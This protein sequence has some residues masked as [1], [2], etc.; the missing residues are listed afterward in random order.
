MPALTANQSVHG[1]QNLT[2]LLLL[3][4]MPSFAVA[5]RRRLSPWQFM[6]LVSLAIFFACKLATW[7]RIDSHLRTR[8]GFIRN[9]GYLFL[10]PGMNAKPFL[11]KDHSVSVPALR[12][13]LAAMIKTVAGFALVS[14]GTRRALSETSPSLFTA[15]AGML[16]LILIL[17]FGAFHLISLA[18]RRFG[19][20]AE[21]IMRAPLQATSLSEFWGRRWNLGFRQLTHEFVFTPV[22]KHLGAPGAIAASFLFSGLIHDLVISVPARGGYCL[23]TAYFLLQGTG[24]LFERSALGKRLRIGSGL[25]GWLFTLLVVAGPAFGLFHPFF[26]R[27]VMLPF[28]TSIGHFMH[29]LLHGFSVPMAR[30]FSLALWLA[31]LGHFCVLIA[32]F[33]VPSRLHWKDDLAKLTSFNRKLMWVHGGFTVLTITAFGVLTLALHDEM[34]RGERAAL[35]LAGFIGVYWTTRLIVDVVY[36]DHTDWPQGRSFLLGHALLNLLF[37]FLAGSYVGLCVWRIWLA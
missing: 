36:Y 14:I 23:P 27:N 6:W 29:Q 7:L 16:G 30:R 32:S 20:D 2:P 19:V 24:I 1:K 35:C 13:W 25:C 10:W 9:L 37:V 34:L 3:V 15:W 33:Q 18:W 28:L 11:D 26:V 21:P 4:L 12:E 31:A 8:A 17:H 22:R 5:L